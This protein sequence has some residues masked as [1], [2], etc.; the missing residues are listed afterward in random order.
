[1]LIWFPRRIFDNMVQQMWTTNTYLLK[2]SLSKE[3]QMAF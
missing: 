2:I 3:D 1:M